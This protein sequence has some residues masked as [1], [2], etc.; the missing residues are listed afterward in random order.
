VQVNEALGGASFSTED[1]PFEGLSPEEI[2]AMVAREAPGGDAFDGMT[3]E[4][5]NTYLEREQAERDGHP[6]AAAVAT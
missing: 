3:P 2:Q 6:P 4:E 5:I 1:D